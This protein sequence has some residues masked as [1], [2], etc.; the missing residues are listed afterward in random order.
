V[1]SRRRRRLAAGAAA[2]LLLLL[3]LGALA[4]RAYA[5]YG[6]AQEARKVTAQAIK[7]LGGVSWNLTRADADRIAA[8]LARVDRSLGPLDA[9][10]QGDPAVAIAR[11]IP[12]LGTQVDAATKLVRAARL[13]TSRHEALGQLLDQYTA[14]R[15]SS[16]G[17]ERI[18]ALV[19][20]TAATREQSAELAAAFREADALVAA[21]PR[22]GL[23]PELTNLRSTVDGQ[24]ARLRPVVASADAASSIMPSALGVGGEKR[25]LVFAMDNAEVRGAGG[26]NAAF[27]TP[28]LRD[29]LL[30]DLQFRDIA[31]VDRPRQRPYVA[32]PAPLRDHLLG[33][34]FPWQVADAGWWPEFA[35]SAREARRLYKIETGDENFHGTIAFT[36]E[37]VDE[38]LRVVG[39][40]V[41]PE[42]GVTVHSGETYVLS[43]EQAEVLNRGEGRKRFLADL[44][45]RVLDRL[46]ALSPD[47]YPDV[48]Q[49]IDR[50]GKRRQLQVLLDDPAAQAAVTQ[51]GWYTPFTF[52]PQTDR[53]AVIEANVAP[54]SKLHVLLKLEHS[55]DVTLKPNG[56]AD[57]RLVT[58]YNNTYGPTLPPLLERVRSTFMT[59]NL[60]TYVRRYIRPDARVV[61]VSNDGSP[62][63]TAAERI[64]QELG[65]LAVG[66]YLYVRPGVSHVET[67]YT[68][69]GVVTSPAGDPA[70]GGT[71]TLHFWKQA[72]RDKDT[73][74]V[75][76]T[77]PEGTRPTRWSAGGTVSG[78]SVT[79]T[80]TSEFDRS[81]EVTYQ[82]G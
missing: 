14:A 49:A 42:A 16:K 51:A 54:V 7:S 10:L 41:V 72:G 39:P 58:T 79:F 8:E 15:D 35:L 6:Q 43:L 22:E 2:G 62:R 26:L 73:L 65:S 40:V 82:A 4:V 1:R 55:L 12:V 29:G 34:V 19:R 52:A 20:F 63:F 78:R 17:L 31:E 56:G 48:L 37:F 71:Y 21:T 67:R 66:N 60:G 61:S 75:R 38:L 11:P 46:L 24:V 45:A 9:A 68:V 69:P 5:V 47:R 59:G 50:A 53:L 81:F 32:P 28:R 64:E 57:E 80:T 70:R 30:M 25:Y 33:G 74:T 27:A 77:V 23:L 18:A 44:A 13:L 76:V 3:F 36:P